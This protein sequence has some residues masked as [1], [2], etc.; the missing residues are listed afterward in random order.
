MT[1]QEVGVLYVTSHQGISIPN[2]PTTDAAKSGF[3][4]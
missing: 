2:Y 4:G 1:S 3:L